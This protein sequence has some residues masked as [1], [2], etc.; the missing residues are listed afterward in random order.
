[1]TLPISGLPHSR[2]SALALARPMY[3]F[4]ARYSGHTWYFH[5]CGAGKSLSR[6]A[7]HV[8]GV[9]ANG[10]LPSHSAGSPSSTPLRYWC[11]LGQPSSFGSNTKIFVFGRLKLVVQMQVFIYLLLIWDIPS[12]DWDTPFRDWDTRF[13][14]YEYGAQNR[15]D[16]PG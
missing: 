2:S 15:A 8:R 4:V 10:V 11:V 16:L 7:N 3:T 14:K 13:E 5:Y 1:M 9:V 12:R 6:V